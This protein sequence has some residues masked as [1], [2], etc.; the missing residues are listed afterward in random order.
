MESVAMIIMGWCF[1]VMMLMAAL[2]LSLWSIGF[3]FVDEIPVLVRPFISL[4]ILCIA[5][6]CSSTALLIISKMGY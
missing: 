6:L 4:F 2:F 1:V 5:G 3:L